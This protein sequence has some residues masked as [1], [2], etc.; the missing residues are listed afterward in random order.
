MKI[1]RFKQSIDNLPRAN[2]YT[3]SL[4]ANL[5]VDHKDPAVDDE[6]TATGETT[7][8]RN[9][10]VLRMRGIRCESMSVPGRGFLTHTPTEHGPRRTVPLAPMYD[11]FD[12]IFQLENS[13]EDRQ[14]L[15][16]W[17][18]HMA[19]P[20]SEFYSNYFDNYKGTIYL[21][22]LDKYGQVIYRCVLA[23]AWPL[24]LGQLQFSS[25]SGDF[26]KCNAQF[27]YRYWHSE[28]TNSKADNFL[29]GVIQKFGKKLGRRIAKKLENE[30]FG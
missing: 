9:T 12:C 25:G 27:M 26:T 1:D 29:G 14:Q 16:M 15:E 2:N 13:Y 3:C 28:F 30:I 24:Q 17:Q 22:Q 10:S 5:S 6:G 7:D 23:D 11:P 20:A 21:E 8:R 18:Q 4:F 19:S